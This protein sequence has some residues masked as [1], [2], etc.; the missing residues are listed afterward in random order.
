MN[1]FAVQFSVFMKRS[2]YAFLSIVAV[3]AL[4]VTAELQLTQSQTEAATRTYN[5]PVRP[6]RRLAK[7]FAAGANVFTIV[8]PTPD[9]TPLA[10]T[11][12]TGKSTGDGSVTV[13]LT[14]GYTAPVTVT[15]YFW[16]Y[17]SVTPANSCWV[18]LAPVASSGQSNYAQVIDSH[19]AQFQFSIA[20]NTPF[21]I[22]SS[23]AITGNVYTDSI[24][25]LNNTGSSAAGF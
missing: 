14:T 12:A 13:S 3:F 25:D 22:Q 6:W 24:A 18:R 17:D 21:L 20:E 2:G 15:V 5:S 9:G 16:Q 10:L 19:Y 4:C 11:N 23:A 8:D 1:N 7:Q